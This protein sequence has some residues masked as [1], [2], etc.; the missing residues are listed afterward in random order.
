[1]ETNEYNLAQISHNPTL[2]IFLDLIK[3]PKWNEKGIERF[4]FLLKV[5]FVKH[6][7]IWLLKKWWEENFCAFL[8]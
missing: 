7:N 6:Y 2:D 8:K 1:M 4:Q 3:N 5:K